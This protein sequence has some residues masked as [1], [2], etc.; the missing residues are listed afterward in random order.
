MNEAFKR[1]QG[2]FVKDFKWAQK[3]L[4]LLGFMIFPV[5]FVVLF[6]GSDRTFPF[7]IVFI[8]VF[9]GMFSTAYLIMEEKSKGTLVS[10]LTTPL[11]SYELLIAKFLFNLAICSVFTVAA[12]FMNG[13]FDIFLNPF[14]FLNI[15]LFAG[16]ACFL[17]FVVGV[18]FKNEQE[19]SVGAPLLMLFFC[20]GDAL[21][22]LSSK[23]GLYA[24]FA[25]YH[26]HQM[27]K[28][29]EMGFGKMAYHSGFN[30]LYFGITLAIAAQYT[31][32]YFSNHREGRWS[33]R[34]GTGL[35]ALFVALMVSG[36]IS[37]KF[38]KESIDKSGFVKQEFLTKNWKGSFQYKP[39]DQVLTVLLETPDQA[40]YIVKNKEVK[41]IEWSLSIRKT[42]P[43]EKGAGNRKLKIASDP[44]RILLGS[45]TKLINERKF[46]QWTYVREKKVVVLLERYCGPQILQFGFEMDLKKIDSLKRNLDL[47]E[48][49][50]KASHFL[51]LDKHS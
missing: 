5:I 33:K 31:S 46:F 21:E 17:G 14:V 48:S 8:N 7:A 27:L 40:L 13:R 45:D 41:E 2:L 50:V 25:D 24:F 12:I 20:M 16:M 51:C 19:L 37:H 22:K 6:A 35:G 18:F 4:K 49:W 39:L 47:F 42:A 30:A 32:F 9:V 15:M 1:I 36:M 28:G 44:E 26:I 23:T 10:L 38:H 11:K 43:D 29:Q 34:L 3:N